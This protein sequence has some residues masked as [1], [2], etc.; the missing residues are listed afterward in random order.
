[1]TFEKKNEKSMKVVIIHEVF[2]EKMGYAGICIPKE[3]VKQGIEVHYITAGLPP[4]YYMSDSKKTYGDFVED[5]TNIQNSTK[6]FD[7]IQVHFLPHRKTVG[8]IKLLGLKEKI[9]AIRPDVVQTFNHISLYSLEAAFAKPALGYKLFTGNHTTASVYPL[10]QRNSHW[11]EPDRIKEFLLRGLPGRFIS[12]RIELC[13]GATED[14]SDVAV[15][16]FGVPE[17]KI[18]TIPLGVD[19]DVFHPSADAGEIAA[20]TALRLSLGVRDDEI[21]CVYTGRF[22]EEKNPLLLAQA[23]ETLRRAGHPYR[24]VFFGEGTQHDEIAACEGATIHAFVPYTE[25][26]ALYRAADIG[27]WPTQESTSMIDAAA[28]G[29][30][31]I[32]NDTIVATERIDGNGITYRL[33]DKADLERA[34]LDLRSPERRAELGAHGARKMREGY[35]WEALVARRLGDYRRALQTSAG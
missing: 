14:C 34:L 15:R 27:V 11:W 31:T 7:G 21:M 26:G 30:P 8:G 19:T 10:A 22:S 23:V 2:V 17:T 13:H 12:S 5:R 9:A 35:S 24:S 25:L 1:M 4:Y 29:L 20:A 6:I 33:N 18:T 16:F 32:V 3:M 28:C